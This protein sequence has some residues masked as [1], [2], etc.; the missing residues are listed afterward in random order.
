MLYA[1][2]ISAILTRCERAASC[3]STWN[4]LLT[5]GGSVAPARISIGA[6]SVD[7]PR[8]QS[9]L[10][11]QLLAGE[12]RT[13]VGLIDTIASYECNNKI[14]RE[15]TGGTNAPRLYQSLAMWLRDEHSRVS[16]IIGNRLRDL[17]T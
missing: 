3:S 8:V 9:A 16:G 15:Q 6:F 10:N 17:N 7:D 2:L 13:V 11:I 4:P 1:T 14:M 5:P 12:L